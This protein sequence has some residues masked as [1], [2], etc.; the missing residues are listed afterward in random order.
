MNKVKLLSI[1]TLGCLSIL[2]GCGDDSSSSPESKDISSD[3]IE[4]KVEVTAGCQEITD[5]A[6]KATIEKIKSDLTDVYSTFG[7]GDLNKAQEMSAA[8]KS[9]VEAILK[10]YPGNCEAQLAY[11]ASI[12]SD[13][14]NN[15][16][17]NNLV[18]TLLARTGKPGASLFSRDM[19]PQM[20]AS[21]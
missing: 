10:K 19:M 2:A 21:L 20:M 4:T 7:D 11:T 8:T 3:P 6:D 12:I 14:A 15:K 9:S 5:E 18:D 13:I 1:L 17:I 16:K